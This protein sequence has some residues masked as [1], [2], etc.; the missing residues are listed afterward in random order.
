MEN[1]RVPEEI[2]GNRGGIAEE[3]WHHDV[4]HLHVQLIRKRGNGVAHPVSA[5]F[6]E[7]GS[8]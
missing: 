8:D 1:T 3:R 7:T 4:Q 2:C 6:N 5:P